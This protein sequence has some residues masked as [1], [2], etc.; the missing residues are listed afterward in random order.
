LVNYTVGIGLVIIRG[1]AGLV[2]VAGAGLD[3][4]ERAVGLAVGVV[5]ETGII[6]GP[7]ILVAGA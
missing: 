1:L 4:L 3:Y 7:V 2:V 6:V 5:A